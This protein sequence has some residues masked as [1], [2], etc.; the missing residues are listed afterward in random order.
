MIQWVKT[1][2]WLSEDQNQRLYIEKPYEDRV[3]FGIFTYQSLPTA[4]Y[5]GEK[6]VWYVKYGI[7]IVVERDNEKN[8]N[9]CNSLVISNDFA[10]YFTASGNKKKKI[11][12]NSPDKQNVRILVYF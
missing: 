10:F 9:Y 4:Q 8:L 6:R 5:N 11:F 7:L 3:W 2:S 1:Q 12:G